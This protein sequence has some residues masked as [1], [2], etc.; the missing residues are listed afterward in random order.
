[1]SIAL[2]ILGPVV[3]LGAMLSAVLAVAAWHS[4]GERWAAAGRADMSRHTGALMRAEA[5]FAAER[6]ATNG[7]LANPAAATAAAWAEARARRA[8]GEALLED[9]RAAALAMAAADAN[10][11]EALDRHAAAAGQ[12]AGLRARVDGP[13]EG[14]PAPPAWFAATSARI[15]A[16]MALRRVL[17]SAWQR[18]TGTDALYAVRDGLAEIAE[19]LGRERGLMNGILAAGRAPSGAETL[20]LGRLRGRQDGALARVALRLPSLPA[21]A[22]TAVRRAQAGIERDFAP[23][24]ARVIAAGLAG[25]APPVPARDWWATATQAIGGVQAAQQALSTIL[26]A[27]HAQAEAAGRAALWRNLAMLGFGLG[28]LGLT[29]WFIAARVVRPLRAVVAALR[30]LSEG[31]L[32]TPIPMARGRDEMAALITATRAYRAVATAAREFESGRAAIVAEAERLRVDSLRGTAAAIEQ[33]TGRAAEA[34]SVRAE[35][36]SAR[37]GTLASAAARAAAAVQEASRHAG[38][39]RDGAA[40]L[41]AATSELAGAV[42][43]VSAQMARAGEATRSAVALTGR[44]RVVFDQLNAS[45]GEIGEV[46][47]LIA[48]IAGRTNLLALNATIEAARA[49]DAGKGFAVVATEV[50]NLAGQTARST[51]QIGTRIAAVESTAR[52]A[53]A[54]LRGITEAVAEID[55]VAIAVGAAIEQQSATAREISNAVETV[56]GAAGAVA[57]QVGQVAREAEASADHADAVRGDAEAM[58]RATAG[59]GGQISAVMRARITEL[60]RRTDPRLTMGE[61]GHPAQLAWA[62]G[63]TPAR[64]LDL[65]WGGAQVTAATLPEGLAE[66]RLVLEGVSPIACRVIGPRAEGLGLAFAGLDAAQE[67]AVARLLPGIQRVAQV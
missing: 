48:D 19:F 46:S 43:E 1:M 31:D 40:G 53:L 52:D 55:Q 8:E 51:E 58:A 20:V 47:R 16:L 49:G 65:S 22:A 30:A 35:A 14:R 39:G 59:L 7:L 3:A 9:A 63:G 33:E 57:E 24:R 66:L 56:A 17:E 13:A 23:L 42:T 28:L 36:L 4:E 41:A 6:G 11:R 38:E 21:E 50:K 25:E 26:A 61:P 64:V 60:E 45:M 2:R 62:G 34:M 5:A 27:E 32:D 15:D 44:G 54:V 67:A 37:A 29:A 12:V 10:L 18:E